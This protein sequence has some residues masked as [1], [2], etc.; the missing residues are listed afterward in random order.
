MRARQTGLLVHTY[1]PHS[2]SLVLATHLTVISF[3]CSVSL[4]IFALVPPQSL[5]VYRETDSP[6]AAAVASSA[7]VS[8]IVDYDGYDP[9]V[10]EALAYPLVG[11]S[12]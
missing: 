2:V 11:G 12:L 7:P 5:C 8:A 1:T 6:T 10:A 9:I 3:I 4:C